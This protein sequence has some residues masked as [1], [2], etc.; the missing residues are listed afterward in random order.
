LTEGESNFYTSHPLTPGGEEF[1]ES[2]EW[3]AGWPSEIVLVLW[4][5]KCPFNLARI[6]PESLV[7]R[8]LTELSRP[9]NATVM[10][11]YT[12]FESPNITSAPE[13]GTVAMLLL[14]MFQ[15]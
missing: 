4:K 5:R 1:A 10:Y 13:I 8:V 12:E 6:E 3:A 7:S 14:S 15:S 2:V 9:L 11:Y